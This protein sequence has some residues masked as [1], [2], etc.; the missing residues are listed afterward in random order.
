MKRFLSVCAVLL[1]LTVLVP[2]SSAQDNT[3][4][5]NVTGITTANVAVHSAPKSFAPVFDSIAVNTTVLVEARD[6]NSTW[7]FVRNG[8]Q[9][10]W[11]NALF[12]NVNAPVP[13][14]TASGYVNTDELNVRWEPNFSR[15]PIT[16]LERNDVVIISGVDPSGSWYFVQRPDNRFAWVAARYI[17]VTAGNVAGAPTWMG[18]DYVDTTDSDDSS[19]AEPVIGTVTMNTAVRT[20]I[21]TIAPD[22]IVGTLQQNDTVT[23]LAASGN[24]DIYYLVRLPDGVLGWAPSNTIYIDRPVNTI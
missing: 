10:G 19:T 8:Q 24:D 20:G 23:V 18:V 21:F 7:Y 14:G 13:Q 16:Q 22:V 17:T 9:E 11:I 12:I 1:A 15:V 5:V 6:L 4:Q 3:I 2:A